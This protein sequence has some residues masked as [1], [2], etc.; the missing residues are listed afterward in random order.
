MAAECSLRVSRSLLVSFLCFPVASIAHEAGKSYRILALQIVSQGLRYCILS[1]HIS[2]YFTI[3]PA[4]TNVPS[5]PNV[6]IGK[7]LSSVHSSNEWELK[8][9]RP[10]SDC[11][12]RLS[13]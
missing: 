5:V 3:V 7:E 12:C 8:S 1:A 6:P 10:S 2:V 11:N 9:Y 13:H 4:M